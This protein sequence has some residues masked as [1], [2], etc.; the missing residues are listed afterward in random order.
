MKSISYL[1]F[2]LLYL[3]TQGCKLDELPGTKTFLDKPSAEFMVSNDGCIASCP[4][5]FISQSNN[6]TSFLWEVSDGSSSTQATFV[7]TF[8]TPGSYTVKLTVA[9]KAGSNQKQVVVMVKSGIPPPVAD[10]SFTGGDCTA[11]C[12]VIFSN[13]SLNATSYIWTFGDNSTTT[14]TN[15]RHTYQEGKTYAV[16]LTA[17][18]LGGT[19]TKTQQ[20]TIKAPPTSKIWDRAF[21]GDADDV[22]MDLIFTPDGSVIAGGYTYS[23]TSTDKNE[24]SR[25]SA[26]YW[27]TKVDGNG[28]KLWDKSYGG[29]SLD[30]FNE[31]IASD[32][33]GF[34]LGGISHSG[35]GSEKSDP[36]R[37]FA[38]FW[39][40]KV[41]ES[42]LKEWDK[43]FGGTAEESLSSMLQN[44]T[45]GGYLLA[46]KSES[47]ISGE[48]SQVAKGNGDYWVVKINST[49]TKQWDRT[50]GGT[51][52]D[53]LTAIVAVPD[54]GYLLAGFSA[55]PLNSDKTLPSRG[56]I[57]Y[58]IVKIDALGN[59]VWDK[60]FGGVGA[61]KLYTAIP[62]SDGKMLLVGSS[63]SGQGNEKSEASRGGLDYWIV[64]INASGVKEW[65]KTFGGSGDDEANSVIQNQDGSFI[66]GGYSKSGIS[67][68]RSEVS[69][70]NQE[71]DYWILKL[72]ANGNKVW[73]KAFGGSGKDEL[74]T[75]VGSSDNTSLFL[76]GYSKSDVSGEKTQAS[77]GNADYWLLKLKH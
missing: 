69:R 4:I 62:T 45:D 38:D 55:S 56:T 21:G 19:A 44:K 53:E 12:E 42:G 6:A 64:K 68:D 27:I 77:K 49:G 37:G 26:D 63:T 17:N 14:E 35:I 10:F 50:F 29:S 11:P 22:L 75:I 24:P 34:L 15:P 73:D 43:T 2:V 25:G 39:V 66:I 23:G 5:T 1:C 20:L 60:T 3:V 40:V 51:E 67:G 28:V 74:L 46:G 59:R 57:D 47:G 30:F 58:W 9:N 33:G 8:M 52:L 61:D 76:G 41:N 72:D 13:K 54:G 18:G 48:K 70:G 65:D 71:A 32:N 36:N 31:I 16:S 7:K